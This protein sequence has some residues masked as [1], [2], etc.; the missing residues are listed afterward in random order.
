MKLTHMSMTDR[1]KQ[2]Q[3]R[4][5]AKVRRSLK[6]RNSKNSKSPSPNMT[7]SSKTRTYTR[8]DP[9]RSRIAKLV[10]KFRRK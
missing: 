5:K 10:A 1:I 9:K 3:Y 8:K 6:I 7:W 4:N 2:K